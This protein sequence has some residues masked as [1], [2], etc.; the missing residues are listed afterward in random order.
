MALGLAF[1]LLDAIDRKTGLSRLTIPEIARPLGFSE[2]S[3]RRALVRLKGNRLIRQ[4]LPLE[5][6]EPIAFEIDW[7]HLVEV[8]RRMEFYELPPDLHVSEAM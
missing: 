1:L 4:Y 5:P 6:Y 3:V 7:A 8:Y 2:A